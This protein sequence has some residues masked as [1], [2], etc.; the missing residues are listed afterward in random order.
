MLKRVRSVVEVVG[1]GNT[2]LRPSD[3]ATGVAAKVG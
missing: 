1:F 2:F 3:L